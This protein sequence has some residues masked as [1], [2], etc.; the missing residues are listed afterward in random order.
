MSEEHDMEVVGTTIPGVKIIT[1]KKSLI[2]GFF[3]E[4][5]NR[6]DWVVGGRRLRATCVAVVE[7]YCSS[8]ELKTGNRA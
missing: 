3:W 6:R 8:T 2:T 1:P 4:T 5:Y 7:V